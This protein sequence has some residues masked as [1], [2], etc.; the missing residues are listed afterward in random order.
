MCD[1]WDVL[2]T[3][4]DDWRL[5]IVGDASMSPYELL[6]PGGAIEHYNRETGA[7]WLQRL[8]TTWPRAVWLNPEPRAY[9]EYRQSIAIV[10]RLMGERM[11]PVTL[12]GLQEAMRSLQT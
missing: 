6:Q 4:N 8:L 5:I 9:W 3:Y 7:A 1:T 12:S 11:F 10:R 2:R